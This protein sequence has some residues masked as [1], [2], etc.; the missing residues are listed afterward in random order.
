[1]TEANDLVE[2]LRFAIGGPK[3]AAWLVWK[4]RYQV[5]LSGGVDLFLPRKARP[6]RWLLWALATFRARAQWDV[7]LLSSPRGTTYMIRWLGARRW[8]VE[9]RARMWMPGRSIDA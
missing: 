8:V 4:H 3:A 5:R 7:K 2:G 9:G 1:M 6:P